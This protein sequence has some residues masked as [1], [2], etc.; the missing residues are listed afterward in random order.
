MQGDDAI[1][2]AI[3]RGD[4]GVPSCYGCDDEDAMHSRS[5]EVDDGS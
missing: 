4:A 2:D 3:A 1:M 5:S